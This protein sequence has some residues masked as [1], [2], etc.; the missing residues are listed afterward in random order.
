MA[1]TSGKAIASLI[2]GIAAPILSWIPIL[3]WLIGL[4]APIVGLILGIRALKQIS[5]DPKISGKGMAIAGIVLCSI[6]M[7]VILVL[8]VLIGIGALAYFGTLSPEKFLPPK[9]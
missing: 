6:M 7:L 1:Q 5:H 4:V 9:A 2:L 8:V 3:G